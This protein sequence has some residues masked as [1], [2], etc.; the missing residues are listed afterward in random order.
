MFHEPSHMSDLIFFLT[1]Y[2]QPHEDR[3][4]NMK[5]NHVIS[6]LSYL[7]GFP[8]FRMQVS[9]T[10]VAPGSAVFIFGI[11]FMRMS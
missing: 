6:S 8:I 11:L 4:Y 2:S 3:I 10:L 5:R 9:G 1:Y 7:M